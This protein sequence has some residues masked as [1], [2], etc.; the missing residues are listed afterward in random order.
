MKRVSKPQH[1]AVQAK[2]HLKTL[3][4]KTTE[5]QDGGS[6]PP[7]TGRKS[8][9]WQQIKAKVKE[10]QLSKQNKQTKKKQQTIK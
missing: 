9:L 8:M 7:S 10:I 3:G 2:A 5:Q 4:Q 6:P 1:K